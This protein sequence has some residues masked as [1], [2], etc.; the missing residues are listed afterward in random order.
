MSAASASPDRSCPVRALTRDERDE[1]YGL[2]QSYFCGTD[3]DRFEADLREKEAVILL[4]DADSG[5]IHGF[6]TLM[7]MT[8]CIDGKDIVAFFSGDTIVDRDYWG[9]TV[10]S[11]LWSQT[12]FGG[13]RAHRRRTRPARRDLLV[14][15]LL[16][17]QDLA[18]PAGVLS[19]VLSQRGRP[20]SAA[21]PAHARYAGR[22]QVRR[23]YLPERGDRAAPRAPR[24]LRPGIADRDGRTASRSAGG[25]LRRA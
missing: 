5:R 22:A 11:R 19:R 9:E 2:L 20:D 3:R 6:S 23:Q 4:R 13:S 7:R 21:S 16:R 18:I 8:A 15:D 12:V 10:L 1:M 17:L 24:R 25:V 14:P